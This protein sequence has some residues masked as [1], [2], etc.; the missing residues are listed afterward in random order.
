MPS[1]YLNKIKD[2]PHW[3]L[4]LYKVAQESYWTLG[5][6][7]L[8]ATK[9]KP[10]GNSKL[11]SNTSEALNNMEWGSVKMPVIYSHRI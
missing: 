8:Q 6:V 10:E 4:L 11:C 1:D 2:F 9:M 7:L 3:F 5:E